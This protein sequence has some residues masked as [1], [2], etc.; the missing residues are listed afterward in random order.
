MRKREKALLIRWRPENHGQD[1]LSEKEGKGRCGREIVLIHKVQL[2]LGKPSHETLNS[3]LFIFLRAFLPSFILPTSNSSYS[4][5]LISYLIPKISL[6]LQHT[7]TEEEEFPT[8]A[9]FRFLMGKDP[10]LLKFK[11]YSLTTHMEWMPKTHERM[12]FFLCI[13]V[14]NYKIYGDITE[15]HYL[16][17]CTKGN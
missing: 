2:G 12:Q 9:D 8:S 3:A 1:H 16:K 13:A 5:D 11:S 15:I 6:H 10:H 14:A 4:M 7:K 17:I